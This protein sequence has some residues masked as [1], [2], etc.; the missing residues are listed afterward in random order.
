[1]VCGV[2]EPVLEPYFEIPAI[3][4]AQ[5]FMDSSVMCIVSAVYILFA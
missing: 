5:L 4:L 3:F 2:P 1:M